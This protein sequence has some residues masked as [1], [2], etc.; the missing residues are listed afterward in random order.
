MRFGFSNR[1]LINGKVFPKVPLKLSRS[2]SLTCILV[3][4][5][6]SSKELSSSKYSA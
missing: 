1:L 3:G 2:S 5:F 6:N 4:R